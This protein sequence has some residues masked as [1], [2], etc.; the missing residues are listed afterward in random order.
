MEVVN[1]RL[2][3]S[4]SEEFAETEL[5]GYWLCRCQPSL[6]AVDGG[7]ANVLALHDVNHIFGNVGGMVANTL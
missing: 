3:V 5:V 6:A 7:V 2:E 4:S 1:R